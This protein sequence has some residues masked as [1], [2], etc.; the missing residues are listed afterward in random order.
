MCFHRPHRASRVSAAVLGLA[1]T[2]TAQLSAQSTFGTLIGTVTDASAA[3]IPG[4][5]VTVTNVATDVQR[6]TTTDATGAY[7]LQNLDAG[8]YRITIALNG[9]QEQ[10]RETDLLAR[11]TA[12]VDVQLPVAGAVENVQVTAASPVIE[13]DRAT[14]DTSISGDDIA[15]LALNFRATNNTSPIIVATLV[16]GACRQDRGGQI[17]MAGDLPFMTSFS[18]DGIS[19]QRT[20]GGGPRGSCFHRSSRSRSSR[21]APPATTPSSC[22]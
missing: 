3:V 1:L 20:R 8:H 5:T 21:S 18:I 13:T 9:F 15:K 12:R 10:T 6:S 19:S 22:R 16:A 11:Q 7:Q 14:I 2:L 4:S 17:S